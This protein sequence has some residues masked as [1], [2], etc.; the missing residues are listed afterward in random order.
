MYDVTQSMKTSGSREDFIR[1]MKRRGYEVK[2]TDDRK[3]ITY[4][5]PN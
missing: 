3:N 1:E 4:T 5:C 2:W